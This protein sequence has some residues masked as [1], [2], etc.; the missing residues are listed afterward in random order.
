VT[1]V[2]VPLAMVE[3]D[4]TFKLRE[5]GDV[6]GLATS[7]A[8]VGQFVPIDVRPRGDKVQV[9]T[10]FRRLEAL[11]MLQ[12]D[13]VLARMHEGMSDAEALVFALAQGLEQHALDREEVEALRDRLEA[14]GRLGAQAKGL[15]EA[16]LVVPGSDLEPESGVSEEVDLDELAADLE[17]RFSGI[18]ADFAAITD[19]WDELEEGP[20]AALLDQLRYYAELHDY[21]S[22]RK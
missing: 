1:P 8:R 18:S 20:K 19:L 15:I 7:I 6:A 17:Q 3:E 21:L 11:R 10:G 4:E 2:V 12:R 9:I 13:Q 5:E 16:A 22:R 14:E